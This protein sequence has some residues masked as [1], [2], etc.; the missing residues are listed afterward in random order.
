VTQLRKQML[1]ELQRRNYSHRTA[2]TYVRIVREFA[3][4]TLV[5]MPTVI[6]QSVRA[7]LAT[8]GSWLTFAGTLRPLAHEKA[9]R[10]A[11]WLEWAAKLRLL[12]CQTVCD[13]PVP[14]CPYP[15][16]PP[17]PEV[18]HSEQYFERK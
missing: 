12:L 10:S 6:A 17:L 15:D 3:A 16:N 11:F 8:S 18:I 7:A 13:P 5:A 4:R 9:F 14:P 2:K 1:E